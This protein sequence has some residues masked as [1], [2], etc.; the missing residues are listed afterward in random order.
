MSKGT[1]TID[2]SRFSNPPPVRSVSALKPLSHP[3][4]LYLWAVAFVNNNEIPYRVIYLN[5]LY[6]NFDI[7]RKIKLQ[8][9]R[10]FTRFSI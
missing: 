2:A 9:E 5:T 3:S 8:W 7:F 4:S 1:F 6:E 10:I